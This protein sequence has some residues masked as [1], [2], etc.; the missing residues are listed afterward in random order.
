MDPL[1][2][3]VEYCG[4]ITLATMLRTW[5]REEGEKAEPGMVLIPV[6]NTQEAESG[7]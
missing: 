3:L 6:I 7:A 4:P 5:Y 2:S 1:K